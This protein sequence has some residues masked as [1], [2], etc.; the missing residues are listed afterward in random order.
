MDGTC[1]VRKAFVHVCAGTICTYF[2]ITIAYG[3]ISVA[4]DAVCCCAVTDT[5]QVIKADTGQTLLNTHW[6]YLESPWK[7]AAEAKSDTGW[8]PVTLPHTWNAFDPV[9]GVA[10]YRRN[11]S[12]YAKS[13]S[14]HS[15]AGGS[16]RRYHLYFEAANFKRRSLST[17]NMS[18]TMS[19]VYRVR[20]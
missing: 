19:A 14:V 16:P 2:S 11:A 13:L 12:W 8:Q 9:D 6:K 20:D 17:G 1:G 10:G 15:D 5:P 4:R 7:H 3:V 18:A